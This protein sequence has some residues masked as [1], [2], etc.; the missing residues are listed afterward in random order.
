MI[1]FLIFCKKVFNVIRTETKSGEKIVKPLNLNQVRTM[2]TNDLI[3]LAEQLG[4]EVESPRFRDLI[5][6]IMKRACEMKIPVL[7]SGMLDVLNENYG[8]LRYASNNYA[9]T[10]EDV[11]ISSNIIKKFNLKR[12]DT[13]SCTMRLPGQGDKHYTL[14]EIISVNNKD[15]SFLRTRNDFDHLTAVHPSRKINLEI[16]NTSDSRKGDISLRIL[17]FM[18]PIGFG[19][20]ALIVAPPKTGK[21][22]LMQNIA[23]AIAM[24]HPEVHLIVLLVGERPEEVT[25]M[26]RS[27]KGEVISSTFDEPPSQ[28]VHVTEMALAKAK[29]LAEIG[30]DVVILMDSLT[31]FARSNNTAIPAS[32][33]VLTGGI[34]VN[35]LQKPKQ[36][37]G[38][39]RDLEEGGSLTIIA[40]TLIETGSKADEVIHEEFKG[41][42]NAEVVLDRKVAERR[43]FPAID[44]HRSGTRKEE[45]LLDSKILARIWL[46]RKILSPMGP[47]EAIEYLIEKVR[48]TRNNNHFFDTMN[49][50][51]S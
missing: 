16:Q 45:L 38:A 31:R 43:S 19:Q 27:V 11:F 8:F 13:V 5:A 10:T 47:L 24:N 26:S 48:K 29:R 3:T 1:E 15:L 40:T 23:D 9:S 18:I 20:R 50:K 28:H 25:D 34:D 49:H 17:D 6:L 35:A 39:A 14:N 41:T 33:K 12:G 21:T 44:V 51:E 4:G 36:F 46:L 2:K 42:G 30:E 37:F 22:T 7:M 32:G